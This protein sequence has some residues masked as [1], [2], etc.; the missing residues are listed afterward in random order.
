MFT[1]F[2][3]LP[4]A[5]TALALTVMLACLPALTARCEAPCS[6]D[7]ASDGGWMV[8]LESELAALSA[9]D[10]IDAEWSDMHAAAM[11]D[12]E[13]CVLHSH[14]VGEFGLARDV[15]RRGAAIYM[16]TRTPTSSGARAPMQKPRVSGVSARGV[17]LV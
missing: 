16:R 4:F 3:L 1:L 14:R 2:F 13:W 9:L 6:A 17:P 11:V 8:A 12:D 5:L 10:I 7:G 15:G